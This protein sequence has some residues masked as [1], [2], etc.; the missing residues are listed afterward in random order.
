MKLLRYLFSHNT[1]VLLPPPNTERAI[2]KV[3]NYEFEGT[4]TPKGFKFQVDL[5]FFDPHII[6]PQVVWFK[7]DGTKSMEQLGQYY[8]LIE[9]QPKTIYEINNNQLIIYSLTFDFSSNLPLTRTQ[10]ADK[11]IFLNHN[12]VSCEIVLNGQKLTL[13]ALKISPEFLQTHYNETNSIVGHLNTN[14]NLA[15]YTT[16]TNYIHLNLSKNEISGWPQLSEEGDIFIRIENA[17]ILNELNLPS[18]ITAIFYNCAFMSPLK[19]QGGNYTLFMCDFQQKPELKGNFNIHAC[20]FV[21]I[22]DVLPDVLNNIKKEYVEGS[23]KFT[24]FY[25]QIC[26]WVFNKGEPINNPENFSTFTFTSTIYPFDATRPQY[27]LPT[28]GV[29]Y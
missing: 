8:S 6:T 19:T 14:I 11:T 20:N 10:T 23:T 28:G 1:Q 2:L 25:Q 7:V 12:L 21:E 17:T 3:G 4:L 22:P 26:Q 15:D 27:N 29:I 18:N 9:K 24:V 13:P 16:P 5:P